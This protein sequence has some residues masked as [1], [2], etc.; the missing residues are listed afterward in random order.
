M[1]L[2]TL[3]LGLFQTNCYL[4][5]DE[6]TK[7]G[8]IFDPGY[9][10][11]RI[12]AHIGTL[13][14]SPLAIVLTHGHFDHVGAVAELKEYYKIP[15]YLGAPDAKLPASITNGE[16]PYTHLIQPGDTLPFGTIALHA[17]ATPG[18]T[19]GSFCFQIGELLFSGDTLFRDSV[20]RTDL[21]GGSYGALLDSIQTLSALNDDLKV[22][23][24]HGDAT[25]MGREKRYNP[26]FRR[27]L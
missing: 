25:T 17:I 6:T 24:G 27:I 7:D 4:L 13:D 14:F 10:A 3:P 18:H 11:K 1:R 26:Y 12:L 16:I 9:D 20:G 2:E 21:P 19:P 15:V 8:I 23:P 22:Y 5:W